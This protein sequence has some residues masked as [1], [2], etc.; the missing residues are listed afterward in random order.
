MLSTFLPEASRE[1]N[2]NG[3]QLK[4]SGKHIERKHHLAQVVHIGKRAM[5]TCE[6]IAHANVAHCRNGGEDSIECR[7]TRFSEYYRTDE[8]NCEEICP[9]Y[10][11]DRNTILTCC[12][13]LG[14]YDVIN[15]I[16]LK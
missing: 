14:Y 15:K 1:Q 2:Q 10:W 11:N 16:K 8:N 9:L 13:S 5:Q 12:E 7:H 6:T 4:A 3:E